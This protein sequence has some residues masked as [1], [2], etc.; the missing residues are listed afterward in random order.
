MGKFKRRG[1][2]VGDSEILEQLA[3]VKKHDSVIRIDA[4]NWM[5]QTTGTMKRLGFSLVLLAAAQVHQQGSPQQFVRG[6][7]C[8]GG[9][10]E[11]RIHVVP[12]SKCVKP[13]SNIIKQVEW[14]LRFTTAIYG[15]YASRNTPKSITTPCERSKATINIFVWKTLLG[16]E[17]KPV[18]G[19][20]EGNRNSRRA[21]LLAF[22]HSLV[23]AQ[24]SS[25]S[26]ILNLKTENPLHNERMLVLAETH[27]NAGIKKI[28][29][30]RSSPVQPDEP[31]WKCINSYC[32]K[33][34]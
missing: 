6:P 2:I 20:G 18:K 27:P 12:N 31:L 34:H 10:T 21:C 4:L 11:I 33:W 14:V 15:S 7:F 17:N 1:K 26:A 9:K 3:A 30:H 25:F 5:Q 28:K 19:G 16:Y 23:T 32:P 22:M 24:T 8:T 13:Q 29:A